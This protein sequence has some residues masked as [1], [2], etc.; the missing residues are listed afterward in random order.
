MIRSR[1]VSM[2]LLLSVL[3]GMVIWMTG[4]HYYQRE[5]RICFEELQNTA[6]LEA[7]EVFHI[8]N[9][10]LDY[11]EKVAEIIPSK[12]P[13][14]QGELLRRM[15][16]TGMV[17]RLGVLLPGDR[18]VTAEGDVVDVSGQ[19]SF[20]EVV[21]Q[22]YQVSRKMKDPWG[23]GADVVQYYAP[24]VRDGETMGILCANIDLATFPVD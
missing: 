19:I 10:N 6:Q 18:L 7:E 2:T 8:V 14:E 9:T 12:Q 3:I 15:G 17:A 5:R 23:S 16:D 13:E 21:T 4:V 24:I 1:R 11:L 20:E 22:Q